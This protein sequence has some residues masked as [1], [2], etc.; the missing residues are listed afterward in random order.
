MILICLIRGDE[1]QIDFMIFTKKNCYI[2]ECKQLYGDVLIDY[3]GNFY[4]KICSRLTPI[5]SFI[6]Q[7]ERHFNLIR[8]I[9][10]DLLE[11]E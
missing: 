4:R 7:L 10:K 5:Y 2:I 8:H 11:K 6:T 1:A 9:S 3:S